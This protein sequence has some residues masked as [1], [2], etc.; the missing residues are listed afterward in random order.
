MLS[1]SSIVKPEP[2]FAS[3]R[4]LL[5]EDVKDKKNSYEKALESK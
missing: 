4:K 5:D 3:V 1:K 2:D